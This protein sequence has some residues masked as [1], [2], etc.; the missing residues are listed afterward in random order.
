[1]LR[2]MYI[3]Y[4]DFVYG[5]AVGRVRNA[6]A[7]RANNFPFTLHIYLEENVSNGN[8]EGK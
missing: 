6:F 4:K 1:M 7:P 8:Y 2:E 3:Q 5:A